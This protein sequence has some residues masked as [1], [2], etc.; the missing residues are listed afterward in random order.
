MHKLLLT[1]L[2]LATLALS[3][4]TAFA[5]SD[6]STLE[7]NSQTTTV[8]YRNTL[9]NLNRAKNYARQA[10]E[11]RNGGLQNYRAEDLMH[12]PVEKTNF[13]ENSD[14]TVTFTFLG[15]KPN[16]APT[17]ESVVTVTINGWKTRIDYNGPMR[18]L[19]TPR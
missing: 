2:T 5:Q 11:T 6:R 14:G 19:S 9:Y 8:T 12:G 13:I 10:A 16:A 1:S 4:L 17:I 7:Q 15:G 3:S 18:S